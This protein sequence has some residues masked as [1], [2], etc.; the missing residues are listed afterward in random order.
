MNKKLRLAGLPVIAAIALTGCANSGSTAAI[1]NG[2]AIPDSQVVEYAEA[3]ATPLRANANELRFDMV[4]WVVLGEMSEQY[5]EEHPDQRPSEAD[6]VKYAEQHPT[7]Q[8]AVADQGCRPAALAVTQHQVLALNLGSQAKEYIQDNEVTLNPRYGA[9][10]A[11]NQRPAP[12]DSL[13]E[14]AD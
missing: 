3:C 14:I 10:D 5:L 13:S 11:E 8:F 2:V 4:Q 1:V 7:L 9:W 6:L 12:L